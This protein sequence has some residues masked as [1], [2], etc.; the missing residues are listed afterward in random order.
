MCLSSRG[1]GAAPRPPSAGRLPAGNQRS[2]PECPGQ[3]P[4]QPGGT[5]PET[6]LLSGTAGTRGENVAEKFYIFHVSIMLFQYSNK[7]L[8]Y[9]MY[10]FKISRF[11]RIFVA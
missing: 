4:V 11:Y 1:T 9:F 6:G 10:L 2:G 7:N 3:Q 8:L 5:L